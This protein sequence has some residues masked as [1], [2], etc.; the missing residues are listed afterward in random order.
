[1]A[2]DLPSIIRLSVEHVG[3]IRKDHS[4]TLTTVYINVDVSHMKCKFKATVYIQQYPLI[5]LR[6]Q[7]KMNLIND[8]KQNTKWKQCVLFWYP[9]ISDLFSLFFSAI[10]IPGENY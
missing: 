4:S 10:S 6:S 9:L 7:C 3:M 2:L 1:M 5:H 8:D